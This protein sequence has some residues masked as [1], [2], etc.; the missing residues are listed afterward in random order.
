MDVSLM[1]SWTACGVGRGAQAQ[2]EENTLAKTSP[3]FPA[4]LTEGS[5]INHILLGSN[6]AQA[7]VLLGFTQTF[8]QDPLLLF[9]LGRMGKEEKGTRGKECI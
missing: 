6:K 1:P 9:P 5:Q 3:G 4:P 2:Q 7:F 8:P